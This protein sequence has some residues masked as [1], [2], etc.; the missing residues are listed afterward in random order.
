MSTIKDVAKAAGVSVSTVS[1][2]INNKNSVN[3]ELYNRVMQVMK[4]MNYRPNILAMNLRK[5]NMNFVGV[6]FYELSGYSSKLFEGT[7]FQL[8]ELGYQA[9]VKFVREDHFE[10]RDNSLLNTSPIPRDLSTSRMPSYA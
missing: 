10:I 1:N 8:E 3:I 9:I 4:E 7:L 6:V 2:I 5:N